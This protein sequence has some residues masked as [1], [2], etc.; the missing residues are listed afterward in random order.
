[1]EITP[2]ALRERRILPALSDLPKPEPHK[3]TGRRVWC[4][5]TKAAWSRWRDDP[6]TRQFGPAEIQGAIDALF[7]YE[8]MVCGSTKLAPEVRLRLDGLGLTAKGKR[9]LRWKVPAPGE[10]VELKPT[11]SAHGGRRRLRAVAAR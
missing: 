6:A 1:M 11:S 5:R 7:L 3:E 2:F 4:A 9:D 8:E 10:V